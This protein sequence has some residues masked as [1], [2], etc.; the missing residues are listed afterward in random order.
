MA[1]ASKGTWLIIISVLL[2]IS[3]VHES[4]PLHCIIVDDGDTFRLN[5]GDTVR[6][7]GIDAPEIF[8]PGV[9]NWCY[10]PD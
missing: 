3:C 8:E 1:Q 2:T 7:I 9:K 5:T 10:F 6:L 4:E